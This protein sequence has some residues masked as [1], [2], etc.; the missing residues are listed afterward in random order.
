MSEA[1]YYLDDCLNE[2]AMFG[3]TTIDKTG[4]KHLA[5]AAN[6]LRWFDVEKALPELAE[7][8]KN[9]KIIPCLVAVAP[10]R[11]QPNRKP[12]VTVAQRQFTRD[13]RGAWHWNWSRDLHVVKWMPLP[14][15][16]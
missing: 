7:C 16:D 9:K 11:C 5:E 8:N 4:F 12:R 14:E 1:I 6:A 10:P 13:R 2:I 15:V 3:E